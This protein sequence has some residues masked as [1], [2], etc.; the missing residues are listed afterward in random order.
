MHC[1]EGKLAENIHDLNLLT[2]TNKMVGT[3][4][5]TITYC[6]H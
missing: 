2:F 1:R 4:I 5:D 3:N 6:Y